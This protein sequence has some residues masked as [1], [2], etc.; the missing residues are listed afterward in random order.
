MSPI[1]TRL[2]AALIV[3]AVLLAMSG[4]EKVKDALAKVDKVEVT[5][6][7]C[8]PRLPGTG[9]KHKVPDPERPSFCTGPVMWCSYCEYEADGSLASSGSLPCGVCVG[10]E[11]K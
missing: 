1:V 9:S 7:Y 11:T 10:T 8:T 6:Q 4:C 3:A 2:Q 5:Q